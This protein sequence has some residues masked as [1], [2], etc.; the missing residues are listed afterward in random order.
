M[1]SPKNLYLL[2]FSTRWWVGLRAQLQ[3]DLVSVPDETRARVP[4]LLW[5]RKRA[6]VLRWSRGSRASLLRRGR[7]AGGGVPRPASGHGAHHCF[8]ERLLP[9]VHSDEQGRCGARCGPTSCSRGWSVGGLLGTVLRY[10]A[11]QSKESKPNMISRLTE[12]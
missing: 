1:V 4:Q 5:D 11:T 2:R 12:R 3:G 8:R 6:R 9:G 7:Q 10:D